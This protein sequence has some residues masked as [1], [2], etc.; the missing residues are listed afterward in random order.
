MQISK[1]PRGFDE[2]RQH[3]IY[4]SYVDC[5]KTHSISCRSCSFIAL[6]HS[7][8]LSFL[9]SCR[10]GISENSPV[11]GEVY[12]SRSSRCFVGDKIGVPFRTEWS[13]L[14]M[15]VASLLMAHLHDGGFL[16]IKFR[17]Q[18]FSLVLKR[19]NTVFINKLIE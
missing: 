12:V 18:Y 2:Q 8:E 9:R 1:G 16:L 19:I 10:P 13:T 3:V 15:R 4:C 5:V 6:P 7:I 11:G 14:S 17:L